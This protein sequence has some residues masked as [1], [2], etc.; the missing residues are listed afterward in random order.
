MLK[1]LGTFVLAAAVTVLSVACTTTGQPESSPV[2]PA[3][4]TPA[5]IVEIQQLAVRYAYALDTGAMDGRMLAGLFA[6]GGAVVDAAGARMEG[7]QLVSFGRGRSAV[8]PRRFIVNHVVHQADEEVTGSVYVVE[9]DLP[10]DGGI[11]GRVTSTGGKYQDVYEKTTDGWRFR[12]RQF[13]PSKAAIWPES[14]P[15]PVA[16]ATAPDRPVASTSPR[17]PSRPAASPAASNREVAPLSATDYLEIR[18]L[19][20]RYGYALDSGAVDGSGS[21]YAALFTADGE[22]HGPAATPGGPLFDAVGREQLAS[23]A[24]IPPGTVT[25][26]GANYVSHFLTNVLIEPSPEGAVGKVA[27]LVLNFDPDG[28]SHS[29]TM[30]GHYEDVYARTGDGWRFR[31]RE[32][33]R[34]WVEPGTASHWVPSLPPIAPSRVETPFSAGSSLDAMDYLDISTLVS[35]YGYGLDTG[36]DDG[37]MY[38]DLFTADAA[39]F[40]RPRTRDERKALANGEPHGPAYT[41]HFLTNIVID[42][43][44]DGARGKQYLAVID[45]GED[46]AP[47]SIFLG[48]RYEDT[49]VETPDGWRFASRNL[50]R[51][52]A[53]PPDGP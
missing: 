19:V 31:S 5:D 53:P 9:V 17:S 28:G 13:V 49:Y 14:R 40:G 34:G 2:G 21:D 42:P 7:E 37:Y 4:L 43:T 51:A 26:R 44:A 32:F 3:T 23:L 16:T 39:L 45:I 11:G 8:Y 10:A 46:G 12:S 33:T 29:I 27:L 22:F 36:A 30:G 52:S 6:P 18:Q 15:R 24:A 38:A 47:S 35:N 20:S 48:G 50:T 1:R 41:R 25:R